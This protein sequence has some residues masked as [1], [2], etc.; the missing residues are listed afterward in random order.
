MTAEE[1]KHIGAFHQFDR[2][3][4]EQQGLGL[5]LVLVQKIVAQCQAEFS[6][7]SQP[8]A[9]TQAKIIFPLAK[10]SLMILRVDRNHDHFIAKT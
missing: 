6:L 2:Q 10:S 1:I 5:G 9:G 8:G 3:K 4:H 7:T